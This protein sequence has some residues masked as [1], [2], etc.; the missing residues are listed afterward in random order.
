MALGL[1]GEM[2]TAGQQAELEGLQPN[3]QAYIDRQKAIV[4]AGRA[5]KNEPVSSATTKAKITTIQN[6]LDSGETLTTDDNQFMITNGGFE[7]YTPESDPTGSIIKG[8]IGETVNIGGAAYKVQDT[9]KTTI[10]GL[11]FPAPPGSVVTV[12]SSD[13]KTHHI[14]N[15]K[16]I[17]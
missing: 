11:G 2:E 8:L 9:N 17:D 4:L 14:A 15:G 3:T 13:G 16:L 1:K 10:V 7:K 12:I 5:D 6:K